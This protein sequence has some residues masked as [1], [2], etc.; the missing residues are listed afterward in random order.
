ELTTKELLNHSLK[1]KADTNNLPTTR[2]KKENT[3]DKAE[4]QDITLSS[5]RRFNRDSKNEK[6]D[7]RINDAR[8]NNETT[9]QQTQNDQLKQVISP[10]QQHVEGIV[11]DTPLEP[12]VPE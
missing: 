6:V 8:I 7:A 11:E 2:Y 3:E 12:E 4:K 9:I 5:E 10:I 1:N